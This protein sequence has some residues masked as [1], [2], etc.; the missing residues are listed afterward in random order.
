[1]A[2]IDLRKLLDVPTDLD[3]RSTDAL[4]K[5]IK[6]NYTSE[7][8]YLKFIH[9]VRTLKGMD[10]DEE[11]AFKSA[12]ATA[13]TMGFTKEAFRKSIRFYTKVL[14]NEREIFAEALKRQRAEKL[15]GQASKNETIKKKIEAHKAKIQKL[16]DEIS[17]YEMRLETSDDTL[18]KER[19]KLESITE[20][21]VKS[22][23]H[24]DE[25]LKSD[26]ELFEQYI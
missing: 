4:L 5:A 21:F 11:T 8:D 25:Q 23:K 12:F 19:E 9:S 22:F 6:E 10:M 3:K 7:F 1:M 17:A 26:L 20:N 14:S 13:K 16:K 2:A 18:Q 24:F 15:T